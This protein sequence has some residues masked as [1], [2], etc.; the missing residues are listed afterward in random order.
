MN[1]HGGFFDA[2]HTAAVFLDGV[3]RALHLALTGL[4]PKLCHQFIELAYAGCAQ[5]MSL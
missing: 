2:L 5:R 3:A 1:S 4:T